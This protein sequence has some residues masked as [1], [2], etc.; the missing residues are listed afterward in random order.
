MPLLSSDY[1][2]WHDGMNQRT[3]GVCAEQDTVENVESGDWHAAATAVCDGGT[4]I[5]I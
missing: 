2:G 3:V 4:R 5:E 1:L